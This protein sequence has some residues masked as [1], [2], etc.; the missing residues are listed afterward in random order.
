[1][2]DVKAAFLIAAG[3]GVRYETHDIRNGVLVINYSVGDQHFRTQA[4]A[5]NSA[6]LAMHRAVKVCA[7]DARDTADAL[8][9]RADARLAAAK[10]E[11]GI[12]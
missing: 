1:M 3:L 4:K 11:A 7:S 2:I 6:A 5:K 9:G 10:Q 8:S 12:S